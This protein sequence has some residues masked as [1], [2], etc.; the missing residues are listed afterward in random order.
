[1]PSGVLIEIKGGRLQEINSTNDSQ[2][3]YCLGMVSKNILPEEYY[4]QLLGVTYCACAAAI[5]DDVTL[6]PTLKKDPL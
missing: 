3:M 4:A 6:D 2:K 1:M 5:L